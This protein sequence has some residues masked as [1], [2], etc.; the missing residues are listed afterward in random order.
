M[1]LSKAATAWILT[2]LLLPLLVTY[3][4]VAQD[5][6]RHPGNAGWAA[7]AVYPYGVGVGIVAAFMVPLRRMWARVLLS[8]SWGVLLIAVLFFWSFF[9]ACVHGD[10]I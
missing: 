3:V 7:W 8:I 4:Y 10:C 2:A 1:K 6:W 9:L 5:Q